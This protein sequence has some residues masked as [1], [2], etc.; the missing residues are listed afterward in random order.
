MMSP[1][2][3]ATGLVALALALIPTPSVAGARL[4]VQNSIAGVRIGMRQEQV[5]A[6]L[7]QPAQI[8]SRLS[9][10]FGRYYELLYGPTTVL[11]FTGQ[12]G[13]TFNIS[14]TSRQHRTK[15][16][17]GVGSRE[18]KLRR[19]IKSARCETHYGVRSCTVGTVRPGQIVT[20]F[21][22]NRRSHRVTRISLGR[23]I[24]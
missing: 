23:V 5:I 24:D 21:R 20:T 1:R 18:S 3:A 8:N 12:D 10:V 11:M 4:V 17:I 16:G 15:R 2:A 14:T 22:I 19:K 13:K 7:G 9:D 6:I